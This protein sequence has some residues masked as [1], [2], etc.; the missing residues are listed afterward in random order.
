VKIYIDNNDLFLILKNIFLEEI[1]MILENF[2]GKNI[3]YQ[4]SIA[5]KEKK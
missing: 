4:H 2:S 3:F 5:G 1:N